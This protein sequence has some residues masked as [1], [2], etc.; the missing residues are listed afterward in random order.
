MEWTFSQALHM[1]YPNILHDNHER[2]TFANVKLTKTA[3]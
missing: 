3:I 2:Y 1:S